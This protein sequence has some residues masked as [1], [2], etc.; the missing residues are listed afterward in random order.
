MTDIVH[1]LSKT[2]I[3]EVDPT[4]Q[5]IHVDPQ[6]Q[7]TV[8]VG[9]P[10]NAVSV[11]NAG[12]VGPPGVQGPPGDADLMGYNYTQSSASDLWVI[13]HNLGY[14]PS[15]QTF[16]VGGLEVVGEVQH[17]STN[18][19]NVEFISPLAGFARLI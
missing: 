17:I 6:T 8:I 13:N 10:G 12:P 16:T 14:K 4:P 2:Q 7:T 11:T 18:Q 19:T 5:I 3:V 15:I 1:V 9:A